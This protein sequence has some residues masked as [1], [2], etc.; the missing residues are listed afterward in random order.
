[1]RYYLI[2]G[3]ASGDLHGGNLIKALKAEDSS[4]EFRFWGGD[5]M[6][7]AAGIP[8]VVHYRDGAVMGISDVLSK[9]PSIIKRLETCRKDIAG[10][11]PDAVILIDYPG[12]NLKVAR[13]CHSA[14]IKVLYYIAPKTWA[15]REGRNALLKSQVD[16]LFII[17]PFEV[18]YFQGK[19]ISFTYTGNP[20]VEEV[21]EHPF[22]RPCEG[23][24]LAILP[25]S[26]KGE[27]SHTLPIC[28]DAA[29]EMGMK[30]VIAGAPSMTPDDYAP[31]LTGRSDAELLF[32]RT[33]DIVKFAAA[34][35]VNSGTASLETALIGTPQVV[36]WSASKLTWFVGKRILRVLDHVKYISLAN[37]CLDKPVFK[38]LLQDDFNVSALTS[39]L[40][41]LVVDG[42]RRSAM[43]EDYASLR[44]L[45]G[46]GGASKRA[47]VAMI[48]EIKPQL[49]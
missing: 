1:M 26:R 22:S 17:F 11:H 35:M 21:A 10:W 15:S 47:A 14:G 36:C 38:E 16:H 43:L 5:C 40:R 19:G 8:P 49:I 28:L 45:L 13:F 9:L 12:F 27:I 20:L 37:L 48:N 42:S 41:T 25:G 7:A 3:E 34:A 31:Y 44:V 33:Y 30:A 29:R 39:E 4:A 24:Y 23:Q 6:S 46:G 18:K 2:A 32:G